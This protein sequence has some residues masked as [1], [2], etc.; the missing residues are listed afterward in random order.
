LAGGNVALPL[1]T[2]IGNGAVL[3]ES[4]G[5]GSTLNVPV[6]ASFQG[7]LFYSHT[8][9][10]QASN[11]GT[12][13]DGKLTSLIGVNLP[14]DHTAT[15]ATAQI[16]T[17]AQGTVTLNSGT[18]SLP[19]VADADASSFQVSGGAS[20][21]LPALTSY[22]GAIGYADDWQAT[23]TGS[24]LSLPSL[25]SITED[26]TNGNSWTQIQA[27]ASG[28]VAL[29]SLTQIG[30][31][32]VLLESD[33]SGSTLNVPVLAGFQGPL[34]E[35]HTSTLQASNSGTILDG[36]LTS[37]IGVN[38]PIDHTATV[39][40][41]QITTFSQG[42]VTLTSGTLSLP[43]VADADAASFQVS[44]GA[45]LTL[46]VLTSYKGAVGYAD[47]WQATGTGSVLSLPTL[48]TITEDTSN[49][50]S[51][52]EIQALS[53][54]NV[55]LPALPK[56]SGGPVLIKSDGAGSELNV[57]ALTSFQGNE[58][59]GHGSTLQITNGGR[60]LDSTLS[61][62]NGVSLIGDASGTFTISASFGFTISGGTSTVQTGTLLDE[63]NL[64]IQAGAT[65]NIEGGLS[66]TG[67]GILSSVPGSTIEISGNLLG[68]TQNADDF[69][70][71]G[72][73]QFD[74]GTGTSKPPQE[75]EAMSADLGA[76]QAGFVNNFGYGTIS[77]SSSTSVELVDLSHNTTSSG[78]EAVYANELIVPSGAT[79]NLNNLHLYVR[80]DQVSGTIVG[81]T[82]TVV[83]SGGSFAL[84]S[85]APGTLSPA[86]AVDDWTFFGTA[87]ESLTVQLNPGG[88]GS[89]P[90]VSPLLGWG[91]V[92]LLDPNN[93][94]LAT[95]KSATNGAIAAISG[96]TLPTNET[97]T[98]Q[99]QAPAAEIS[100]TGNYVLSAYNVTPNVSALTVN[101]SSAGTIHS[102]YGVDEWTFT[103]AA[104]EQVQLN[105]ISTF[106]GAVAFDLTGPG[107]YTAFTNLQSNSGP[108]T[109]PSS[110]TY[111]LTAEGTGGQ[112]GSYAFELEQTSVTDLTLGT[113][114]SGSLAGSGQAQLF[115]VNVLATQALFITLSDTSGDVNQ[116]YASLGSPPTLSNFQYSSSNGVTASPQLL[117]PSAAP[118]DWYILVYSVSVPAADSFSLTA[119]GSPVTL[120]T[121]APG[122][123]ATGSTATLTLSGSGFT[124]AS[125][126]QLVSMASTVFKAASV[127]LDT[128]TQLTAT[129]DLTDVP[130]GDYSVVVVN[131]GGQDATLGGSFEVTAPGEA[132]FVSHLVLPS[133]MGRHISATI[134]VEYSNT[135][136][137]AMPAPLLELF[138]PPETID[139]QTIIN[140][141]LL[142]LN[143]ALVV[144]G[145]WTSAIP[146]GYSNSVQILATGSEVPGYLEPG[147][148]ETVPVYYAGMQQPWNFTETS[149]QFSLDYYTQ[150]DT[151]ALDFSSLESSL[152]P[153]G[154]SAA[155]WNAIS[156]SL[157][158]D[159][160]DTWG[161]YVTLLDTEASYLGQLGEDVTDVS[162]L[163]SFA[164]MRADGLTPTPELSGVTD[165]D[166][167]VPGQLSL[168][169]SRVYQE[170]ISARD[171]I[172]PL[173]YGW[174]DDWQYS[175][176][177]GSDGTVTVTM[178]GGEQRVFQPDSRGSDYFNQP[179]DYGILTEGTGGTFSLQETN[180]QIE[181][182]N[183]NGTLDYI[184]DTNDNRITAGYNA[185]GVLDSLTSN[186]G[187]TLSLTYNAQNLIA[188]VTSS[189]GQAV[190][191]GYD[192]DEDL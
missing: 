171:A 167:A 104:G 52:T 80:G 48:T 5:S 77:L 168:D 135:G 4:D 159:V 155:A 114:Y 123:S 110:G 38:L 47:D 34:F 143:P 67:S 30:N 141:P 107:G 99:V 63:G 145:Y 81:G 88:G 109:L 18:L 146:E 84:N 19:D 121:V 120:T 79:L 59:D 54:G 22:K 188:S 174:S 27:L 78:P 89:Q 149:F 90:A 142:T 185:G 74:S 115:E 83:P 156:S 173:G 9:T 95:A 191:Y 46:P 140:L 119:T 128:F 169:F 85:P 139:G 176:A 7:P 21:T 82:V 172:G 33:G 125:S 183:A 23:G 45:S 57:P 113:P 51:W 55:D 112:G 29:P 12:I 50:N 69:N 71:Q 96:F 44:G 131:P 76:N 182:F 3:L 122:Q 192:S 15:V 103:G 179:G 157:T 56:I 28:N 41:A 6:L 130:Q 10:L 58:A 66:I 42:T 180:G 13:F 137:V 178:P 35:S 14:I 133:K 190:S 118:G 105:V 158:T 97:Y 144:S 106:G 16:S 101:Q 26:T 91:Q 93:D 160:G 127:S 75:L 24:V 20:L 108:I 161:G 134:L 151:T 39:A 49:G 36:K 126:V 181:E 37:L 153:P 187:A 150:H 53:G 138:A 25:T 175:L 164:I 61:Q 129:F 136:N 32:A 165:L 94:V 111:T 98:I 1:L 8:S 43:D 189:A 132:H 162:Q 152:E 73:V 100:S 60:V 124:G 147:E 170:P 65:L 2:Q 68:T 163:W 154:I 186:S 148:S 116:I 92:E 72:T 64:S 177:V 31:G 86:G 70:P 117:V 40:T 87:G 17:F 62:V 166:V 184:Q 102:G 11:S